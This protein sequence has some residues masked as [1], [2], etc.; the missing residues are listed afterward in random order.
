MEPMT[1]A[2]LRSNPRRTGEDL[3]EIYSGGAEVTHWDLNMCGFS[4]EQNNP[5]IIIVFLTRSG[6]K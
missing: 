2:T 1:D 4:W 6:L 5:V 3:Q